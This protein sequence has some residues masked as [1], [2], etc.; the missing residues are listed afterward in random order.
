M[1]TKRPS[2]SIHS[3]KSST[4]IMF[5]CSGSGEML[6]SYV[7][8][9]A[10]K[11]DPDWV[12]N[13]PDE[14]VYNRYTSGW[15]DSFLSEDWFNKIVLPRFRRKEGVKVLNGNNLSSHISFNIIHK[16]IENNIFFHT[17]TSKQHSHMPAAGCCSVLSHE[18][19][20]EEDS[21]KMET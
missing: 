11:L 1:G 9:K 13:G 4:S 14:T 8:Y 16:C 10:K 19:R 12:Q 18:N 3:S 7:V 15:F 21:D 17:P 2:C 6:P 5:A 20:L